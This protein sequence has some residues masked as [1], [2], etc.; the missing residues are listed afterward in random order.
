MGWWK[1]DPATGKPLGENSTLSSP[2]MRLL[3]AVP[4]VDARPGDH[5]QG[6]APWD[7]AAQTVAELTAA[8][9]NAR[10]L[11]GE[12]LRKLLAEQVCPG[13]YD[14]AT[15]GALLTTA[16]AF[17]QDLDG[18][19]DDDW[20]RPA[21]P[22][23]TRWTIE[24]AVQR[25]LARHTNA[26]EPPATATPAAPAKNTGSRVTP[27]GIASGRGTTPRSSISIRRRSSNSAATNSTPPVTDWPAWITS[28]ASTTATKGTCRPTTA[29]CCR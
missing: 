25:F 1:I 7:I 29:S 10:P 8:C 23:E 24:S 26:G 28:S 4:G 9:G 20:G 21:T 6:D 19:Y 3:N 18:V 14:D 11:T 27:W 17:R 16:A 13:D 22:E 5:Y 12:E 2:E 15:A